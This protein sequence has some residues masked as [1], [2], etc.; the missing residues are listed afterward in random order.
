MQNLALE[1]SA[2]RRDRETLDWAPCEIGF[3]SVNTR[4]AGVTVFRQAVL[5]KEGELE[6]LPI[7]LEDRRVEAEAIL[8]P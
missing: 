3:D 4:I 6:V 8:V 1:I 7:F 2:R 5:T